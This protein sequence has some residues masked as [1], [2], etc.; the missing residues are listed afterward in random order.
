LSKTKSEILKAPYKE[1]SGLVFIPND[2]NSLSSYSSKSDAS[3]MMK[4]FTFSSLE[5]LE[6]ARQKYPGGN[7]GIVDNILYG[8]DDIT[9][10]FIDLGTFNP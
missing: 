10:Q 9:N 7:V 5:E 8:Y 4:G 2:D 3:K 1:G 6:K